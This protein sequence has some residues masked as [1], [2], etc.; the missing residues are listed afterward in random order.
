MSS[1]T[2]TLPA[3]W[4]AILDEMH[5]RLD[6]A[7]ASASERVE[8]TASVDHQPFAR[9]THLEIEK[10]CDRLARLRTYLES[11]E[12]IVQSVDETLESEERAIRENLSVAS[13]LRQKLATVGGGAIG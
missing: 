10:W 5:L 12:Q 1:A 13:T 3:H 4:S 9:Q 7:I 8:N 6:H 11:A 2:S